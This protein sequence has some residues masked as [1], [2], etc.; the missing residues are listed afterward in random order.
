MRR[1]KQLNPQPNNLVAADARVDQPGNGPEPGKHRRPNDQHLKRG[2]SNTK[3]IENSP[4]I[5]RFKISSLQLLGECRSSSKKNADSGGI[6]PVSGSGAGCLGNFSGSGKSLVSVPAV[7]IG[8]QQQAAHD[9]QV[10]EQ[11]NP[12]HLVSHIAVEQQGGGHQ[13][14]QQQH[15]SESGLPAAD[16]QG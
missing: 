7:L 5:S 16:H 2:E 6:P 10:L 3:E 14:H 11:L 15:R 8:H 4:R 1:S 12:L 9:R 13:E